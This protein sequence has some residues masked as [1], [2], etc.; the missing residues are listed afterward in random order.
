MTW[1]SNRVQPL[2]YHLFP[3]LVVSGVLQSP[4]AAVT[5]TKGVFNQPRDS[6]FGG[7]NEI[8]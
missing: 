3:R 5:V 2:L 1:K 6:I 4:S 7:R 8:I